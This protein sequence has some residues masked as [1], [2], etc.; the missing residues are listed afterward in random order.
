MATISSLA[1]KIKADVSGMTKNISDVIKSV[2]KMS[3]AVKTTRPNIEN[4]SAAA[5]G[6][7]Q[8]LKAVENA[9]ANIS[10][11][12]PAASKQFADAGDK[13]EKMSHRTGWGQRHSRG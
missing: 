6:Y 8:V 12:L 11:G 5:D 10:S 13:F 7:G 9:Q 3:S 2:E 4:L 1:V